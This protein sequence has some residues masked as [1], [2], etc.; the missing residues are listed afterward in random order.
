MS[1]HC[2]NI[3]RLGDGESETVTDG[4]IGSRDFIEVGSGA[5]GLQPIEVGGTRIGK[6]ARVGLVCP[7]GENIS[8]LGNGESETVTSSLVRGRDFRQVGNGSVGLQSVKVSGT[9]ICDA[10]GVSSICSYGKGIT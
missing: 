2:E 9:R 10:I 7:D 5:V 3:S 1:T 6:T 4:L 8:G